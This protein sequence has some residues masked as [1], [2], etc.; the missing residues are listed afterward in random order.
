VH[1]SEIYVPPRPFD[2][3]DGVKAILR[4]TVVHPVHVLHSNL[5]LCT[6]NLVTKG[7]SVVLIVRMGTRFIFF[8]CA[9]VG[10]RSE[11]N[12]RG[13]EA[14]QEHYCMQKIMLCT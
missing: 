5:Q 8:D 2:H 1:L 4:G 10:Y 9:S 12:R 11:G 13:D 14:R 7:T 6:Q 3:I